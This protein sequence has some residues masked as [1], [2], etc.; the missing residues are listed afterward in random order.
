MK[1][2]LIAIAAAAAIAAGSAQALT[3][4]DFANYTATGGGSVSNYGQFANV[5]FNWADIPYTGYVTIT[6]DSAFSLYLSDY[7]GGTNTDELSGYVLINQTTSTR[8]TNDVTWCGKTRTAEAIRGSCNLISNDASIPYEKIM[9]DTVTAAYNLSAGS[10]LLGV[11]DGNDP[12]GSVSFQ[13]SEIGYQEIISPVPLPAGG[14]LL[15]GALGGMAARRRFRKA[16]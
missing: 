12:E 4:L 15:L 3:T 5:T 7:S 8:L 10:Y 6:S 16:A 13:A 2:G 9:P 1:T 14:M 11:Y